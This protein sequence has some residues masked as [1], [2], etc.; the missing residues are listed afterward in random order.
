[1]D[2]HLQR[3]QHELTSCITGLSAEQLAWHDPEKWSVA[4][5]LEHLYLTYTGT[6]RGF[7]RVIQ[8][9]KSL[10]TKVTLKHRLRS[11]VVIGFGHMPEGRK[12]PSVALPRGIS[13]DK[14][15]H[16]I[17]PKLAE[18]DELMTRCAASFGPRAKLLDHPILGPFSVNQWCKF[19]LVHGMLHVKQIHRLR[20]R[21]NSNAVLAAQNESAGV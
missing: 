9:G 16:D 20:A 1:M 19:H 3:L 13:A 21:L 15:I 7:T 2:R 14:V 4:E 8:A 17:A 11:L 10:A 5:I 18:M 12:S 6:T